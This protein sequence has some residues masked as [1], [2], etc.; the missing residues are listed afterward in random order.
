MKFWDLIRIANRNL[1]RNKL[2]TFLTVAAIFVGSFTLTMTNGIGDGVRAYIETQVKNIESDRVILVRRKIEVPGAEEE[3]LAAQEYKDGDE[4]GVNFDPTSIFVT[5]TQVET[6]VKGLDGVKS[7]TP[8][9]DMDGEYITLD[10]EKKYK[11]MLGMISEGITTKTEAGTSIT[12]PGQMI[13]PFDLAKTLDSKIENLIGKTATIAF[14]TKDD[15]ITTLPLEVV[16][17]ATKGL[18]TNVATFVDSST[19]ERIHA[20]QTS[21]GEN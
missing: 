4:G 16:G 15:Q 9:Y 1:F 10:G 7:V 19:A 6:S 18:R 12:G 3:R 20:M 14:K 13:L 2:R 8:R 5:K 11:V 17:V 21:E